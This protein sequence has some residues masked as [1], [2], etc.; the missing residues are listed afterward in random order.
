MPVLATRPKVLGLDLDGTLLQHE[1]Y[2]AYGEPIPGMAEQ[3]AAVR[4]AGW[5]VVIW[6]CRNAEEYD[7]IR[8]H[9]ASFGIEVDFINEN[10]YEDPS[11]SP[12]IYCDVYLDDRAIGF[13]GDVQG[14]AEQIV[15]FKPWHKE[16]P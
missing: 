11:T 6:T 2:P 7:T 16:E 5:K 14:L 12:K 8:E 4:M 1:K 13:R 10:P 15:N 3:I 9:L